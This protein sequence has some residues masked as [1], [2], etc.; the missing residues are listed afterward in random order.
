MVALSEYLFK[1][2]LPLS[3]GFSD[4]ILEFSLLCDV[5]VKIWLY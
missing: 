5:F 4:V 3:K 1:L 2:I